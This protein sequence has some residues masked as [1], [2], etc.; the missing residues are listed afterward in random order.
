[1]RMLRTIITAVLLMQSTVHA[2]EPWRFINLADWH[3]A[4]FYVQ[5]NLFPGMAEE[6]LASL[7]MLHENYGGELV[8]L[9]GDSNRGHWDT[10]EF[11]KSFK[12]G[13]TPA[14]AI[15]QAGLL[16]YTGMVNAFG[17]PPQKLRSWRNEREEENNPGLFSM[18]TG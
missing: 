3:G 7:K 6:N 4:E 16:C 18:Q 13:L 14:Q 17:L 10:P 11:I 12:A 5:P 2:E 9:P 1:M 15:R 8:M